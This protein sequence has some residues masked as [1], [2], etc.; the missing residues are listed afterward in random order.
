MLKPKFVLF[1]TLF[2]KNVLL[3]RKDNDVNEH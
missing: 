3:V 1:P 2:R